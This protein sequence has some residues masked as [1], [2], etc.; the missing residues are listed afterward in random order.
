MRILLVASFLPYPLFS[1]GH[2]RL[3]NL[4]KEL[5]SKHS[6]T[7]VCEKR[8]YQTQEDVKEL[9]K[10]CVKVIAVERRKQWSFQNV[11]KSGY[12]TCPFLLIGHTNAAMKE[13][14]KDL[15]NKG[16]FDLIH[17]ETFYVMQNIPETYLPIVLAEH[18]IEYLVYLRYAK[19]APLAI[20]PLL[21]LDVLKMKRWEQK[22]WQKATKLVAVSES[23]KKLMGR[24]DV[25]IVPN[26][27]DVNKFKVP[28]Y[29]RASEGKQISKKE[30]RVLFIG[31]FKWIQNRDSL[32]WILKEIWPELKSKIT[33]SANSGQKSKA[34]T[35]LW[36]VG[37]SIPQ[38]IKHLVNDPN[39]I[40]DE[41]SNLDASEIFKKADVLLAPIR[42][43]G[44]TSFKILEAMASGVPVVT[45]S[46]GIEGIE[47]KDGKE[48]FI[49]DNTEDI[50]E[51]ILSIF[52]N[53]DKVNK[54]RENARK[55]IEEK[56]N[57]EKIAV[58]LEDVYQKA[59]IK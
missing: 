21:Y 41:N 31:D 33:H 16:T 29:A 44:G 15:L 8:N 35:K 46:L 59:I 34:D 23:E 54:I 57:W 13:R 26:G 38:S 53:G 7:L 52:E 3:Y 18:N 10:L 56:Y 24:E 22:F 49:A 58:K 37:K 28:F 5:S 6:I 45:T 48:V 39:I 27:V 51:I 9:E 25:E 50:V 36:V 11:L 14:I 17:V 12:S 42:V 30:K 2:V 55:L 32:E 20:R 40:F 47:V 43:G 4:I 19:L 1:G